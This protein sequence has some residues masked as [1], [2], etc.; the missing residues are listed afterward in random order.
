MKGVGS[1][2]RH[3]LR[4]GTD[5]SGG[6]LLSLLFTASNDVFLVLS[7][8]LPV[9]AAA[10]VMREVQ[11]RR[12]RTILL[13]LPHMVTRR[14]VGQQQRLEEVFLRRILFSFFFRLFS[15]PQDSRTI[16]TTVRTGWCTCRTSLYIH[17]ANLHL[18]RFRTTWLPALMIMILLLLLFRK[19]DFKFWI[20]RFW[21]G[22]G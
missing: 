15:P 21:S 7:G 18:W 5:L 3:T 4:G 20:R 9:K 8:V 10:M 13:I 2:I 14:S 6:A 22:G 12:R 1:T 11:D 16:G 19:P 17:R